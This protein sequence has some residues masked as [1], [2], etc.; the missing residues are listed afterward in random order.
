MGIEEAPP[1]W[2]HESYEQKESG[3]GRGRTFPLGPSTGAEQSKVVLQTIIIWKS[4][5]GSPPSPHTEG[6]RRA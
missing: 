3:H 4:L 1:G 6:K 2:L 5:F